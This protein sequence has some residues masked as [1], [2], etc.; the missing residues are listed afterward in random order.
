MAPVFYA[1]RAHAIHIAKEEARIAE[2]ESQV[3]GLFDFGGEA[4]V[5][6]EDV[7]IASRMRLFLWAFT[8]YLMYLSFGQAVQSLF[9]AR[10]E[11]FE[12]SGAGEK[13]VACRSDASVE[14]QCTDLG[15]F[16]L[17]SLICPTFCAR[18]QEARIEDSVDSYSFDEDACLSRFANPHLHRGVSPV[19]PVEPSHPSPMRDER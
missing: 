4:P 1:E 6:A 12:A 2:T 15:G 8:L 9:F 13:R 19:G 10:R 11:E 16:A 3:G 14:R 5:V 18:P 7:S 17:V